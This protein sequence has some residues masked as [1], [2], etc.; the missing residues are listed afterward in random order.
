MCCRPWEKK[1]SA[2]SSSFLIIKRWQGIAVCI[3]R[4]LSSDSPS[5]WVQLT[6][7]V[8]SLPYH[9]L[10]LIPSCHPSR[11]L[12]GC[13]YKWLQV[14]MQGRKGGRRGKWGRV[15]YATHGYHAPARSVLVQ[16]ED[17]W[18]PDIPALNSE[19]LLSCRQCWLQAVGWEGVGCLGASLHNL[20]QYPH[21]Q[22]NFCGKWKHSSR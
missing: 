6:F 8:Q 19:L 15:V 7:S 16:V 10:S 11:L 22:I 21:P 13:C 18:I 17:L 5:G 20:W 14:H 3:F 12:R 2:D 9:F 4:P 1:W